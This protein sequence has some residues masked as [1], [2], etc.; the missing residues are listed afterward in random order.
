MGNFAIIYCQ[1][2]ERLVLM[3]FQTA[4]ALAVVG[5]FSHYPI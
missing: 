3:L 5:L 4:A 1:Y 2:T